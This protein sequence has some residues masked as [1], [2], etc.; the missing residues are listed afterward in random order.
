M[1][2][3]IGRWWHRVGGDGV[4]VGGSDDTHP[5]AP[6]VFHAHADAYGNP[7]ND[8]HDEHDSKDDAS[9]CSARENIPNVRIVGATVGCGPI[10]AV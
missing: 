3:T 2:V 1:V 10:A 7:S 6:V 5:G 9:N 4:D 8:P